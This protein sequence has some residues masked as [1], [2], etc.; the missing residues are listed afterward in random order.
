MVSNTNTA[1]VQD[2]D[3]TPSPEIINW[4]DFWLGLQFY[5]HPSWLA[6][7]QN[8]VIDQELINAKASKFLWNQAYPVLCDQFDLCASFRID[9][10]D[11]PAF[12]LAFLPLLV[13][14]PQIPVVFAGT[15]L[16]INSDLSLPSIDQEQNRISGERIPE[17]SATQKRTAFRF[18][19]CLA[20]QRRCSSLRFTD[21]TV[22]G[23]WLLYWVLNSAYP[24][25]WKRLR[26]AYDQSLV[27]SV[28]EAEASM[29]VELAASARSFKRLWHMIK[30]E[31][32]D[33]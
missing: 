29:N 1:S 16:L 33:N 21:T 12:W 3:I 5:V 11:V 17:L 20:L 13:K 30:Q 14:Q 6:S 8:L 10:S 25:G 18:G 28:E 26:L 22:A 27:V 2:R 31:L 19:Q 9:N 15:S 23:L 7:G 32:Y 4:C 24:E